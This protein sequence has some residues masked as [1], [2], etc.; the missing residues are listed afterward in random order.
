MD[1][2]KVTERS[3][4]AAAGAAGGDRLLK[5][6]KFT[7]WALAWPVF[8]ELLLQFLLG[9]ADT[10]MVSTISD[11]AVAVVGFSSQ[12]FQA[13][14]TLFITVSS[15]AGI[16]IAQRLGAGEEGEARSIAIMAFTVSTA[17]GL[18][19]SFVLYAFPLQL[20]S[21]LQLPPELGPLAA[22]YI[23]IVGAGMAFSAATI[24][25]GT[26]IR[27]TGN[28]RG[29]MYVAIGMNVLHVAMN[30]AF[31]YGAFGFPA[32]GLTG[33]AVSTTLSRALAVIVLFVMFA[34]AFEQR[35]RWRELGTFHRRLFGEVMKIGWPL[36]ANAAS[37]F[38]SQL[39]I[40]S[41][42]AMIGAK[43][44]AARTYL[45]TMESFCFML[46]YSVALALQIQVAHL[47]GAGAMRE[48]YR[49]AYRALGIGLALVAANTLLLVAVGERALGLFTDDPEIIAMG[50]GLIGLNLLL[51]P[52]KMTNM[53]LGNALNAVG[54][55]RFIMYTSLLSLTL[56]ATVGSYWFGVRL[57]WGLTAIYLCMIADELVRGV[58]SLL[59]WKGRKRLR[60]AER[61]A[62]L[63]DETRAIGG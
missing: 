59:R 48:A 23:S 14:M 3:R 42:I 52:A 46:G 5:D 36:G 28:T 15:G 38:V 43:E 26:V 62:A 51:Q 2:E 54:D 6:R 4:G 20:A 27:S 11:D 33:V 31:I 56:V 1:R 37:W 10:L 22:P 50:V 63:A 32:W 41:F 57:G 49:S 45:N 24:A 40:F 17:I 30:Y 53:A 25:L 39:L 16:L 8:I 61:G 58:W 60:L 44:L 18:V 21:A 35:I 12:L 7:L 9:A 13:L 19:L 55:T 47:Y 34:N 29:P